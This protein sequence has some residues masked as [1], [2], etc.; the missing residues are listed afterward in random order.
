MVRTFH[1]LLLVAA[2]AT[3]PFRC[4]AQPR[5]AGAEAGSP[6]GCACCP[7]ER[8]QSPATPQP[9][10]DCGCPDCLCRGA[11]VEEAAGL[12]DARQDVPDF[13]FVPVQVAGDLHW[14]ARRVEASP[15]PLFLMS[16]GWLVRVAIQSFLL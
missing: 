3:C 10:D 11:I 4:L 12:L 2:V 15:S 9:V 6:R 13:T 7:H 16:S 5:A 8:E 1:I 14:P